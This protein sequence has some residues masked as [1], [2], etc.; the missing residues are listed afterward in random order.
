M[1][2]ITLHQFVI[3]LKA[4]KAFTQKQ[5]IVIENLF[6][7][8]NDL[9]VYKVIISINPDMMKKAKKLGFT[10]NY[11]VI[12]F[13]DIPIKVPE[14]NVSKGKYIAIYNPNNTD[15]LICHGEVDE[16]EQIRN[17]KRPNIS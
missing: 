14:Q 11:K 2:S 6:I 16:S 4:S 9:K 8:F 7:Y 5:C 3:D 10:N 12:F 1:A 17:L 15:C 13:D